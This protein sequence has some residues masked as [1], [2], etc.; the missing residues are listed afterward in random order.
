MKRNSQS[1][2][3]LVPV[4]V[5]DSLTCRLSGDLLGNNGV[6]AFTAGLAGLSNNPITGGPPGFSAFCSCGWSA[7]L[8]G[9]ELEKGTGRGRGE[10]EREGESIY[11]CT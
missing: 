11:S 10:R 8:L 2:D 6:L 5:S 3:T 9:R 7:V 4:S 1:Q